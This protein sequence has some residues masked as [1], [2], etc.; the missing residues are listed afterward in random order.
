MNS[1]D[2]VKQITANNPAGGPDQETAFQTWLSGLQ[3]TIEPAELGKVRTGF[4]RLAAMNR[5]NRTSSSPHS[6]REPGF[7]A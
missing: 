7:N 3:F 5:L 4:E 6:R 1:S 2:G